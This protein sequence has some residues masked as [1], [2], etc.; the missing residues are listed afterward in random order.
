MKVDYAIIS[1]NVKVEES[2]IE[3]LKD[4][5]AVSDDLAEI[6]NELEE[7]LVKRAAATSFGFEI[8]LG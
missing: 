7:W 2:K 1:I 5:L 8:D 4:E 6:A 3:D